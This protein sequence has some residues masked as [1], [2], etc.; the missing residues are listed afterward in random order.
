MFNSLC[1]RVSVGIYSPAVYLHDVLFG[2]LFSLQRV[3]MV[4]S[5][6]LWAVSDSYGLW[7]LCISIRD[8]YACCLAE[9]LKMVDGGSDVQGLFNTN[10]VLPR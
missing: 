2:C 6:Q 7:Q 3:N 1:R 8:E 10:R 4:L 9:M 5:V